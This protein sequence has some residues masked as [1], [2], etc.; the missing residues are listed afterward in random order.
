M[1]YLGFAMVV[2][3]SVVMT[4]AVTLS[5][6]GGAVALSGGT[7]VELDIRS[8]KLPMP[9]QKAMARPATN[10]TTAPWR[11]KT[12]EQMVS[13][14]TCG[15]TQHN[16]YDETKKWVWR[17]TIGFAQGKNIPRQKRPSRGPPTIPK[18]LKAAWEKKKIGRQL[19][20][21]RPHNKQQQQQK[22]PTVEF[23]GHAMC[24]E[25]VTCSTDPIREA[26]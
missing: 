4:V 10:P 24:E 2:L 22:N 16:C 20:S 14:H 26:R 21:E 1:R 6:R 13:F 19:S 17:L 3:T 18:M 8:T 7:G 23:Y 12:G 11:G 5:N 15:W 25:L 9:I